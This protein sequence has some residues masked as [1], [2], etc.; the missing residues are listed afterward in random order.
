MMNTTTTAMD[1]GRRASAL[2]IGAPWAAT[3]I[4]AMWIG[5]RI[6]SS[7]D[8]AAAAPGPGHTTATAGAVV[9]ERWCPAEVLDAA[10][11]KSIVRDELARQLS[12]VHSS[13]AEANAA[14]RASDAQPINSELQ[15]RAGEASQVVERA[16]RA[17]RWSGDDRRTFVAATGALPRPT[18]VELQRQLHVAINLGQVAVVDGSPPFGPPIPAR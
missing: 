17:G 15:V 16:I 8:P 13:P 14:D 12:G 11:L 2:R 6:G 9:V 4:A 5:G 3:L 1:G 18:V 10:T 7:P